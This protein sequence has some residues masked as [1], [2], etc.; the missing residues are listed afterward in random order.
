MLQANKRGQAKP[1]KEAKRSAAGRPAVRPHLDVFQVDRQQSKTKPTRKGNS[2]LPAPT[3]MC[4]RLTTSA[5]S[6]QRMALG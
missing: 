3:F 2:N 6:R 1:A 4:S 5:L